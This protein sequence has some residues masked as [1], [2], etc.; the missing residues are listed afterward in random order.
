MLYLVIKGNHL[1]YASQK[2]LFQVA[3]FYFYVFSMDR[4]L[5]YV[6]FILPYFIIPSVLILC[7]R[8]EKPGTS[9][10]H[11]TPQKE[12][13]QQVKVVPQI[14]PQKLLNLLKAFLSI[15]RKGRLHDAD[16]HSQHSLCGHVI[17]V[18]WTA[19]S[20][21]FFAPAVSL[22]AFVVILF[23]S[24]ICI[25]IYSP[26]FC[27]MKVTFRFIHKRPVYRGILF[28]TLVYS[29]LS[30]YILAVFSC[31]FVVRMFGFIIMGLT[32]NA[33]VTFP[34]VTF[35]FVVWRNIR[36]CFNNLQNRYKQIKKMIAEQ[37][38]KLTGHE[39]T[40]PT[41]LF[42]FVCNTYK[43]LPFA[44]ELVRMLRNVIA[45]LVFLVIA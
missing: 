22:L 44:N 7:W 33:E 30:V 28:L 20:M 3:D 25:I 2:L 29:S 24:V 37:W 23:A 21:I 1:D 42:W 19:L 31:Q 39:E 16:V 17:C 38:K 18:L 4:P 8:P 15:C 5:V 35:V 11:F 36:L 26:Y 32:L 12:I 13:L 43:V 45:I 41:D 14:I 40:I 27:L 6:L 9:A 34:Q 10:S